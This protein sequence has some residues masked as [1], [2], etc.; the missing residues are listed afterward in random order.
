MTSKTHAV[1]AATTGAN[2]IDAKIRATSSMRFSLPPDS[3]GS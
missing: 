1:A 3:P 2:Q